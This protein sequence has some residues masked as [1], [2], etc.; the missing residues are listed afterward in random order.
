MNGSIRRRS[1]D[2]WELTIDLGR[3]AGGKRKRKYLN[4]RG[5]KAEAQRK[6]RDLLVASDKGIPINAKKVNVAQ[7]LQKWLEEYVIPKRR[8]QTIERYEGI[9]RNHLVPALGHIELTKL[10]PSDI[11]ALET[12]LT[13]S[14]MAPM[15]VREVHHVIS[16]ALKYA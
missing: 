16:G 14:G 9:I 11:Q 7:W 3:D 5:T 6:L 12:K 2:S 15:G 8:Q 13:T 4:I 1:K 10:A